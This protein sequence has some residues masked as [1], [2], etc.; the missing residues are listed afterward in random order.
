MLAISTSGNSANVI[1]AIEAAV[2]R[3]MPIVALTGHDGGDIAGLLGEND[4]EIRVPSQRSARVQ[5][6]HLLV[7]HCLCEIIDTT[8]FP[9]GG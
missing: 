1:K 6:V 3:D 8:L 7:L 2:A 4:V 5:E 9:Q